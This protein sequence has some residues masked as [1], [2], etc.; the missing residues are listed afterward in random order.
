MLFNF[1]YWIFSIF[2][3]LTKLGKCQVRFEQIET[4]IQVIH[5]LKQVKIISK[6]ILELAYCR[7]GYRKS[8]K[9]FYDYRS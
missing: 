3:E 4:K 6:K 5:L 8:K 7:T 2:S 9:C 1:L